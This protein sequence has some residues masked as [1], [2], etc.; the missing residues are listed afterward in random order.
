MA[1]LD[2]P[3]LSSVV[4]GLIWQGNLTQITLKSMQTITS[5]VVSCPLTLPVV[6]RMIFWMWN[7]NLTHSRMINLMKKKNC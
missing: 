4:A 6:F 2:S 7:R 3:F 5:M 1:L